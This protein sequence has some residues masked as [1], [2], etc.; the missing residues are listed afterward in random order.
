MALKE[1]QT[2]SY[3]D[4]IM[5]P[6]SARGPVPVSPPLPSTKLDVPAVKYIMV[7]AEDELPARDRDRSV[8]EVLSS[9]SHWQQSGPRPSSPCSVT[10]GSTS[11]GPRLLLRLRDSLA[12]PPL[13]LPLTL[14]PLPGRADDGSER[15]WPH[16]RSAS[17]TSSP[18]SDGV[19]RPCMLLLRLNCRL[20]VA[21]SLNNATVMPV[22][23]CE[24]AAEDAATDAEP[25]PLPPLVPL[26]SVVEL[27]L[28]SSREPT[29]SIIGMRLMTPPSIAMGSSEGTSCRVQRGARVWRDSARSPLWACVRSARVS[30]YP[31]YLQT[32]VVRQ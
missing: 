14:P 19:R 6:L 23:G 20:A 30:E 28:A 31:S 21:A 12:P 26:T 25:M 3:R 27:R 2:L 16:A 29:D 11:F 15:D 4:G 8:L 13:T 22:G 7:V 10:G 5:I 17:R 18:S 32:S 24:D 9:R 1:L